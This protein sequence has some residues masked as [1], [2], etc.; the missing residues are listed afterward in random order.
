MS[1]SKLQVTVR[2]VNIETD[3]D[4]IV[5]VVRDEDYLPWAKPESCLAVLTHT[6]A[7]GFYQ[8]VAIV[9][10]IIAGFAVWNED[11]ENGEDFLYLSMMHVDM[12]LR[13]RGIGAA[14]I[15]DGV[16]YAKS[17]G[18]SVL[19]TMPEDERSLSFYLR[20]G[21]IITE[22]LDGFVC[23]AQA[24]NYAAKEI[25]HPTF[26]MIDGLEFVFGLGQAAP[27][28]MF[29]LSDLRVQQERGWPV[30]SFSFCEGLLQFRYDKDKTETAQML[31]WSNL[32]PT[33]KTL[34]EILALGYTLGFEKL[35]F[36][37]RRKFSE[38]FIG[39]E[40]LQPEDYKEG[41]VLEKAVG[42]L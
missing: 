12:D 1:N 25:N 10:D 15:A 39:R 31:Y 21:F 30:K 18:I 23:K 9:D 37:F 17:L 7:R 6:A 5:R 22:H 14:M 24:G 41:I 20:N 3:V 36:E 33:E 19:R 27:Q 16:R 4:G 32:V 38:L 42:G 40:N 8:T 28:F 29:G 26:E 35:D 11:R 2:P 13:S 34:A